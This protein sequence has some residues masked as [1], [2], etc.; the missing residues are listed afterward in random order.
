MHYQAALMAFKET[1][2]AAIMAWI[3]PW[4]PPGENPETDG[5]YAARL[6][7][8]AEAVALESEIA[9]AG[10][11]G[12]R[13]LAAATLIVWYGETRFSYEVHA[14]GESRWHQDW[15][16]ARCLGQLHR[17]RLVPEEEWQATVGADLQSTR[18]C[19]RAT[20]RVLLA[21]SRYC[22]MRGANEAALGRVFAAYG[23]G[24]G[25]ALTPQAK[26]R[27]RRWARLMQRI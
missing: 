15:G 1:L 25:C 27:A 23:S 21:Q 2:F 12:R 17:S 8:I 22:G 4:Y 6:T 7:T 11:F 16:Q 18:N 19:A 13:E 9:A 20:M 10:G 14:R 3:P 5:E 24:R 26:Q